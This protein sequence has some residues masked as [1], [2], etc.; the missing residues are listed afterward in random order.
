MNYIELLNRFEELDLEYSFSPLEIA[1]YTRLLWKCNRLK[2]KN[3]F[4]FGCD[5]LRA[6]VRTTN[7]DGKTAFDTARNK[8][9]QAGLIDYWNGNGR[10]NYTR[11]EVKGVE[12]GHTKST[13]FAEKESKKVIPN[14]HLST[15]FSDTLSTPFSKV[16]K[17]NK[18]KPN[19]TKDRE[20]EEPQRSELA[21]AYKSV[22]FEELR[23]APALEVVPSDFLELW[24]LHYESNGWRDGGGKCV[25]NPVTKIL[26]FWRMKR[27]PNQQTNGNNHANGNGKAV[28]SYEQR[29]QRGNTGVGDILSNAAIFASTL[30]D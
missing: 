11:Y 17:I 16:Q 29:T 6:K 21:F 25:V 19:E 24:W 9:K 22:S 7:K 8:L 10:G 14:Q 26:S 12:K 23:A 4:V 28:S 27:T 30:P 5:E 20:R 2:W 15:P 13:P 3:P 18:T 1:I